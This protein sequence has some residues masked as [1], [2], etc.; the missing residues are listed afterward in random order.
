[1]KTNGNHM[2]APEQHAELVAEAPEVF[3]PVAH[4]VGKTGATH[5]RLDKATQ[6]VLTGALQTA[7]RLRVEKDARVGG[8]KR[9]SEPVRPVRRVNTRIV[10]RAKL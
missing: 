6:D 4:R 7:Y 8:R 1:M 2:L 9:S 5:I 10:E 3:L